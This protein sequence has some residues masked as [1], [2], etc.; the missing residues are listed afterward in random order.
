MTFHKG[1]AVTY[2]YTEEAREVKFQKGSYLFEL[3]GGQGGTKDQNHSLG[4]YAS[5]IFTFTEETTL[6]LIT[7]GKG[8]ISDTNP[9][10]GT[11]GG[12]D[13]KVGYNSPEC[14]GGG[15]ATDIRTKINEL[16]SRIIVAGGGGGF[17]TYINT[18]FYG[19]DG[20][21]YEGND[22]QN[23]KANDALVNGKKATQT[24]GGI[25]VTYQNFSTKDGAFGNAS[26]GIGSAYSGGG[27]GGGYFGGSGAYETGGGGGSGYVSPLFKSS[28]LEK[29]NELTQKHYGDGLIIVTLLNHYIGATCIINRR[30]PFIPPIQILCMF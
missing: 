7:G 25:G 18:T 3:W 15:G 28:V 21:G 1:I 10:G 26:T 5:G 14:G 22:G 8:T 9:K 13:G 6:F 16:S 20:G 24:R 19:G 2:N 30:M 29:G 23:W 17:G 11:N 12:G 4:G 27:G